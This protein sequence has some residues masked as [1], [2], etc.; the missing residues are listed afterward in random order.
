MK[1]NHKKLSMTFAM[2]LLFLS[3]GD[4]ELTPK[5][6]KI[7]GPLGNY[8]EVLDRKYSLRPVGDKVIMYAEIKRVKEGG[9]KDANWDSKPTFLLSLLDSYDDILDLDD[10]NVINEKNELSDIFG[11]KV[12]ETSVIPFEFSKDVT[13]ATQIKMASTWNE[14]EEKKRKEQK[15]GGNIYAWLAER[16]VTEEDLEEKT[17][18]DIRIMRNTIYA[19]HG[20]I[21]K[22]DD[23]KAY[24]AEQ[25]WYEPKSPD[26]S[27]SLSPLEN[28]NVQFLKK[29]E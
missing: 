11:L 25:S 29:H 23:M 1:K 26:V 20:Y 18:A 3:C 19:M 14:A 13:E 9:P 28:Q 24:F 10:A 6:T 17:K 15:Q 16:L 2:A 21:F 8:F 27:A 5:T 4:G 12:G 22:T 7:T